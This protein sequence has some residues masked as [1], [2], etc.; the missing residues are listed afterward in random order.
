MPDGKAKTL[1]G[2]VKA[3]I[4]KSAHLKT[5]EDRA[6]IGLGADYHHETV[7]HS[8]GE[9]VRHYVHHTNTIESVWAL[10]KR[11]IVGI[12]HWVSPKHLDRYV[13]EMTFRW[14]HRKVTFTDRMNGLFGRVEGRLTY[15]A[16]IA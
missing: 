8:E 16:L 14:N 12:H 9:Y 11:Q 4:A 13:Q 5:D 7:N 3:N 15:K 10:L 1:Q 6:F 2:A